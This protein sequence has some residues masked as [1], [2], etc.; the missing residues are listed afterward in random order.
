MVNEDYSKVTPPRSDEDGLFIEDFEINTDGTGFF[1]THGMNR[2]FLEARMD[3]YHP[4]AEVVD[5]DLTRAARTVNIA[6]EPMPEFTAWLNFTVVDQD[7]NPI[8]SYA[9]AFDT[10]Y[11]RISPIPKS[12]ITAIRKSKPLRS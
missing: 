9:Y 6:L 4:A 11:E 2:L 10:A 8:P 7:G 5:M 3:G 1:R 12:P